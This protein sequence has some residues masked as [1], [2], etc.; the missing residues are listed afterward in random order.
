MD[1][2]YTLFGKL[3]S[4]LM[5]NIVFNIKKCV[6]QVTSVIALGVS[7]SVVVLLLRSS[8][9]LF[10]TTGS[11]FNKFGLEHLDSNETRICKFHGPP[12][13][14]QRGDNLGGKV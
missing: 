2:F 8:S 3:G 5:Y 10:R 4:I 9:L 13:Q 1:F 14:G 12:F 6:T 11:L 7:L